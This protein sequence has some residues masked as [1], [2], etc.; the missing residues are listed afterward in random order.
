[1][2]FTKLK[3]K[4]I[5]VGLVLANKTE[6]K[7]NIRTLKG[8][9]RLLKKKGSVLIT[10]REIGAVPLEGKIAQEYI[11]KEIKSLKNLLKERKNRRP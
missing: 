9:L 3:S 11:A 4:D 2:Q 8:V 10:S 7:R 6:T 1:M 5:W